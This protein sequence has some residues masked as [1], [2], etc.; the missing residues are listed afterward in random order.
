MALQIVL[1]VAAVSF[2]EVDDLSTV[3][4]LMGQ[5]LLLGEIGGILVDFL[6]ADVG[7]IGY[8]IDM[9]LSLINGYIE[10]DSSSKTPFKG[11]NGLVRTSLEMDNTEKYM[12]HLDISSTINDVF[13][14]KSVRVYGMDTI[15]NI[16]K[17][18][19]IGPQ[20][21][22]TTLILTHVKIEVDVVVNSSLDVLQNTEHVE[23]MVINVGMKGIKATV[24]FLLAIFEEDISRIP[25]GPLLSSNYTL[26][27]L[28][29]SVAVAS[30][31]QLEVSIETMEYVKLKG[32]VS[33]DI[34]IELDKS[35][36]TL[37]E[38]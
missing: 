37:R 31:T 10:K 22:Q 9:G 35:W 4:A 17:F 21:I 26:P 20:T 30:L 24:A 29:S 15:S 18:D 5:Y 28:L 8:Y 32:F 6:S 11:V 14:F 19:V 13:S 12:L 38:A 3:D 34:S 1:V 27:C 33:S 2:A 25:L 7:T 16:D 23:T 36:A